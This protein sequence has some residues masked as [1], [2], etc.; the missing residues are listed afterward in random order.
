MKITGTRSYIKVEIEGKVVEIKGELLVG[1]FIAYKDTIKNWNPPY[2]SEEIDDAMKQ[3]IIEMVV[4]KT[5]KSHLVIT[6]E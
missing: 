4:N 6:F 1:S 2:E 5:K 3:K